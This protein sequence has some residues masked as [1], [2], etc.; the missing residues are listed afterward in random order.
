MTNALLMQAPRRE[1]GDLLPIQAPRREPGDD[2]GRFGIDAALSPCLRMGAFMRGRRRE[3]GDL[4]P[5]Q[6]PRREPG[7][8]VGRFGMDAALS[9][10]LRM[11]AFMRVGAF[12]C[13]VIGGLAVADEPAAVA[14]PDAK[15]AAEQAESP[16]QAELDAAIDAKL[17]ANEL[18][19]Y[20][21][22]LEHC[23]KAIELGLDADSKKFADELYTGTLVDRAGMLVDAIYDAI[24]DSS[25]ARPQL[26]NMRLFAMRDLTEI[27]G[28]DPKLGQAHLMIARLQSLPRGDRAQARQAAE[29][30]LELLGDDR[31]QMA[32]AHLVLAGLED[33]DVAKQEEHYAKAIEF[34]PRD[35]E[36]R[37]TRG[38]HF[39]I[40]DKFDRAREDLLV[41]IEEKPTDASLH[42]ALGMACM[43][44]DRKEEAKKAF[45]RA[46]EL[47]PDTTSPLLQR[48]RLLASDEKYAE[49][50]ADI[51]RALELE[52]GNSA[53]LVLR[54]R[55]HQQAGDS[56]AA[57]ED[58][59]TVLAAEPDNLV[60]LELR[61]LIAAERD[62]LPAA[63]RDF[64]R[65]VSR[66]GDAA[67]LVSQLGMLYL[68]AKQPRE[69][70][71]RFTRALEIDENHFASRRGRSDAEISIGNHP[72]AIADLEKAH[73]L[74]PEDTGVL[75]NLA[76]LLATS[77]DDAIRDG[78]RAIELA[79]K[80]CELTE[81]KEAHIISTLAAG[82][83]ET[84]DFE[85]AREFSKKAVD[86]SDT[87]DEVKK[88]LESE[89]A[90]YEEGKPWRERQE[91]EEA[92]LEARDAGS[93]SEA[94]GQDEAPREP[95]RPFED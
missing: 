88:Q 26:Q 7:D 83:A 21:R 68:A 6:A 53:A 55:V 16:G 38:L 35:V 59:E 25:L 40:E 31:L 90:S 74:K 65:L 18:D 2:A 15:P 41:A 49:A 87:S 78:K 92:K 89:L 29:K 50:I 45:D 80:A 52:P 76:W 66:S 33:D 64:R 47:E 85:K 14:E 5:I 42:E 46:I 3:P 24:Y 19:D 11:G 32:K 82:H 28:R 23:K 30:A 86:A 48:A 44:G 91:M 79:E 51:G 61:G 95:R 43:L 37:R 67:V 73:A 36:I 8:D 12:I 34:A 77:P 56:D 69:A 9:P 81:W 58:I 20:E 54:G 93:A 60:A 70:I 10:C 84:G 39:L 27:I 72:A 13:L 94:A 4:L 63:I 17:G 57:L 71:K 75:N 1:P 62:D 22:V